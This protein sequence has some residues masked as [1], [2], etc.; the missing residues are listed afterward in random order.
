MPLPRSRTTIASAPSGSADPLVA[1]PREHH[2]AGRCRRRPPRPPSRRRCARTAARTGR[3]GRCCRLEAAVGAAVGVEAR[4]EHVGRLKVVSLL[5]ADDDLLAGEG[6]RVGDRESAE[7]LHHDS[8]GA[9]AAVGAAVGVEARQRH[10]S[11]GVAAGQARGAGKD[12]LAAGDHD[13]AGLAG[14]VGQRGGATVAAEGAVVGAVG[15]QPQ[16]QH[17]AAVQRAGDDDLRAVERHAAGARAGA[18]ECEAV[19][20]EGTVQGPAGG[21][22]GDQRLGGWRRCPGRRPQPACRRAAR[23]LRG[24]ACWRRAGRSRR[25]RRSCPCRR[26][27]RARG[28]PRATAGR[29][30]SA[31][32]AARAAIAAARRRP[33]P[34]AVPA[35]IICSNLP[36]RR[37]CASRR[38]SNEGASTGAG[39]P[40]AARSPP[41]LVTFATERRPGRRSHGRRRPLR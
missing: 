5:A 25:R 39:D 12:H 10:A 29:R 36:A 17:A 16:R 1:E 15:V 31:S 38:Q 21:E 30:A 14:A 13:R 41:E 23:R 8:R 32:R 26:A 6:D 28:R 27:P 18:A 22:A 24:G 34:V 3:A 40:K 7:V 33:M 4:R 37:S 19:T 11:E 35:P 20:A 2:P 9:E